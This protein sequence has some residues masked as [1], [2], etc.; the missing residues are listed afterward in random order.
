MLTC[1]NKVLAA[2]LSIAIGRRPKSIVTSHGPSISALAAIRTTGISRSTSSFGLFGLFNYCMLLYWFVVFLPIKI[3]VW[4]IKRGHSLYPP[5]R[6]A[7]NLN[8][9]SRYSM[10]R[11]GSWKVPSTARLFRS[12]HRR[13]RCCRY[14]RSRSTDQCRSRL[15]FRWDKSGSHL[16]S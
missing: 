7:T 10:D 15:H 6:A 1:I 14:V 9:S 5:F 16:A 3:D 13:R 2:L 4:R 8:S 12:L 11:S